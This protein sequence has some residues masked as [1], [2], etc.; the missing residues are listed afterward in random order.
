MKILNYFRSLNE[1][2]TASGQSG[3]RLYN[4]IFPLFFFLVFPFSWLWFLV[5][6]G[7]LIIDTAVVSFCLR[8]EK[9]A[10]RKQ[11]IKKSWWKVWGLG[12]LSD[13]LGCFV[14]FV[15]IEVADFLV[16]FS[17]AWNEFVNGVFYNPW[18]NI[19]S[20]LFIIVILFLIGLIIYGFNVRFSFRKTRLKKS[21]IR[22]ISRALAICTT[23]YVLLIPMTLFY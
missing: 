22:K 21:Q 18:G 9:P 6:F 12:Y 2:D 10:L 20:L 5:I 11:V 13:F 15:L 3:I 19:F 8:K 23:P 4:M 7:N 16:P 14:L 1:T 17:L